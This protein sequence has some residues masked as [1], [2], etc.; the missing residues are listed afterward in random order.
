MGTTYKF[1]CAKCQN[2]FESVHGTDRGRYVQLKSLLCTNKRIVVNCLS[3][4]YS[5]STGIFS[6]KELVCPECGTDECLES[7]DGLS[8]N[9]CNSTLKKQLC[10]NWD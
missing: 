3:G 10:Y 5:Q 1:F 8:C 4:S 2:D 7:W 9:K 6:R